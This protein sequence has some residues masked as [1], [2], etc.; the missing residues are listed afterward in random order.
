MAKKADLIDKAK[1]LGIDA[2]ESMTVDQINER[3]DHEQ[4]RRKLVELAKDYQIDG[5]EEMTVED[6]RSAINQRQEEANE[7]GEDP[8]V[9]Q[10]VKISIPH[11]VVT[12]AGVEMKEGEYEMEAHELAATGLQPHQYKVLERK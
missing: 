6:L 7:A 10:S 5:A 9:G 11:R 1:E 3:I 2:D 4:Q 8:N 12:P